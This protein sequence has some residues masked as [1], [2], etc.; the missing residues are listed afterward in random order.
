MI[1]ENNKFHPD[2]ITKSKEEAIIREVNTKEKLES[3]IKLG[4]KCLSNPDFVKYRENYEQL[5]SEIVKA[6]VELV[7]PD[8]VRYTIIARGM[9]LKLQQ[10]RLLLNGVLTDAGRKQ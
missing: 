6:W 7:E 1:K 10:L 9:A 3:T 5:E 8:P 2:V 4:Q